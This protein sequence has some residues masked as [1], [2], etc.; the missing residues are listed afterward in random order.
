MVFFLINKN[1]VD[2]IWLLLCWAYQVFRGPLSLLNSF[3]LSFVFVLN[4]TCAN[5]W[6]SQRMSETEFKSESQNHKIIEV[7]K[8]LWS[9]PSPIPCS[10]QIHCQHHIRS[11]DQLCLCFHSIFLGL[12]IWQQWCFCQLKPF[13]L[14]LQ[15]WFS[16]CCPSTNICVVS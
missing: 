3:D 11:L 4:E 8:D 12:R 7:G 9:S 5:G 16:Q 6:Q 14:H 2:V 1:C 10:K 13:L 15:S